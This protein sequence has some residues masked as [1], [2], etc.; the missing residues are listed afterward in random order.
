MRISDQTVLKFIEAHKPQRI[1]VPYMMDEYGSVA[2]Y[3]ETW[4][5]PTGNMGEYYI[6]VN[7]WNSLTGNPVLIEWETA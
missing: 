1:D 5:T 6:E 2:N 3:L 7:K 4:S